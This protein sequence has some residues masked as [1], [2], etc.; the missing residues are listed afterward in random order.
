MSRIVYYAFAPR[1]VQGGQKMI[2]R[3]VETLRNLGFNAVYW[4]RSRESVPQWVTHE[5]PVVVSAPVQDGDIIVLPDDAPNAIK[6]VS[7]LGL[8]TVIFCQNPYNMGAGSLASLDRFPEASFPTFISVGRMLS[9]LVTRVYPQATVETVPCF[10][11]ER[12][13]HPGAGRDA[14]ISYVPRKRPL[15]A[16][17]IREMFPKLHARHADR[18]WRRVHEMTEGQVAEAFRATELFLSLSRLESV[19]ITTLEAMASGCVCA[20]FTGVGGREYATP[21]NGFWAPEDDCV[22]AVDALAAA[23][24]LVR[25]GGAPLRHHIEAGY[26]TARQWSYARFRD[27]LEEVWMRL[28]PHARLRNGPLD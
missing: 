17:F 21:D 8:P 13:F 6:L 9:E 26:E 15:E 10:A 20:G 27:A 3:H 25:T 5:A 12:L 4:T 16:D 22:A 18:P 28:A 14:G 11:D 23:S 24:D 19:G 1:Q 7:E 2:L